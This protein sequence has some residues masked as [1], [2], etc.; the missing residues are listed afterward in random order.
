VRERTRFAHG[1][2]YFS[3][4]VASKLTVLC[5]RADKA[6]RSLRRYLWR[7]EPQDVPYNEDAKPTRRRGHR[8]K[9]SVE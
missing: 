6:M 5:V 9:D 8:E 4:E 1:R 2:N 7:V 3:S